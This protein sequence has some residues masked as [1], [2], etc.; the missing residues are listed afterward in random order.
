MGSPA[1]TA[2]DLDFERDMQDPE[3]RE[4]YERTRARIDA[5]D[6]LIRALDAERAAQGMSKAELARRVGVQP[7]AMRRLFTAQQPNPTM[8][9]YVA[10]AQALGIDLEPVRPKRRR[11]RRQPAAA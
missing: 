6:K 7:E 9:T 3:F 5:V 1:K 11:R 10:A 2:F 8:T 4:A